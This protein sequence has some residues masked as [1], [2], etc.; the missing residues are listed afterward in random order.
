MGTKLASDLFAEFLEITRDD[1]DL[2]SELVGDA[3]DLL[4]RAVE[5]VVCAVEP[6]VCSVEL[7]VRS[8]MR[9]RNESD[10]R[11]E[12]FRHDVEVELDFVG[13]FSIHESEPSS[14]HK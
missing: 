13:C 5:P 14:A 3:V 4:V 12:T 1:S 6:V 9:F 8:D 2:H 10:L 7:L 11:P